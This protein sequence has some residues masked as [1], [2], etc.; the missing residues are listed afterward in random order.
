[1]VVLAA[2]E[3]YE[4]LRVHLGNLKEIQVLSP[5]TVKLQW[6]VGAG[7]IVVVVGGFVVPFLS[8]N[9]WVVVPA[10]VLAIVFLLW[11]FILIQRN[12]N[13]DRGTKA[14]SWL[15]LLPL[16]SLVARLAMDLA[17]LWLE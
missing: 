13:V 2:L 10:V 5:R 1:V 3:G 12:P 11:S 15:V 16:F 6:V 14:G 8:R 7:L 9:R 4:E 17:A